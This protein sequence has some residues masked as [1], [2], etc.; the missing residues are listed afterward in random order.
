VAAGA[1]LALSASAGPLMLA[2]GT[3]NGAGTITGSV[4]N[5][6]GHAAPT[7]SPGTR[8]LTGNYTQGAAASLDVSVNGTSAPRQSRPLPS[9]CWAKS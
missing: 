3:P 8:T 2:G 1:N 6:A 7:A 4:N 5:T 9:Q